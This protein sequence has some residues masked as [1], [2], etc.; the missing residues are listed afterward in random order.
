MYTIVCYFII[1]WK[2]CFELQHLKS[3]LKYD[4]YML[5]HWPIFNTVRDL[6]K[7]H[8][9]QVHMCEFMREWW[10]MFIRCIAWSLYYHIEQPV[11]YV[12]VSHISFVSRQR[13]KQV[14]VCLRTTLQYMLIAFEN[15]TLV[16]RVCF[17]V[18]RL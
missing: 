9:S 10:T 18:Y 6:R 14:N 12:R 17:L 2:A 13:R 1:C 4:L 7:C 8:I 15:N 5:E 11:R 16:C 3:S